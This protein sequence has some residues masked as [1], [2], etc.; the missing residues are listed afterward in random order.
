MKNAARRIC[1]NAAGAALFVALAFCLQIPVWENYTL[2]LGY[3]V[4]AVWCFCF[5]PF[6]GTAAGVL[7]VIL[8]CLLISGLRG[9]PGWALAMGRRRERRTISERR[10]EG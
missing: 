10:R 6:E 2:C 5:G 1:R 8:Y 9:M 7:G 3:A 4:V